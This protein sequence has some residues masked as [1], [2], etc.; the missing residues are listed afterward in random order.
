MQLG[1]G[2]EFADHREYYPGD[3]FRYLDW[4]VFARHDELLLKRFQEEE[5]LHVYLLLDC[6]RSMAFGD[7]VEVRLCPA[8]RRGAGLHRAGRP[9]PRRGGRLA[10]DIVADFPLTR[11]KGRIL[12]LLKFL[13]RL[14]TQGT[15]TD[16]PRV[17]TNFV[18]RGQRRGLA[19]V[20]SDLFDP[21]GFQGGLDLLR[22][23]RYEPHVVQ[24]V[25]PPR[26]RSAASRGTSSS[27][28][29]RAGRSAR[30]RSP[31]GTSGSTAR[32]SRDFLESVQT[33]CNAYGIGGT[34][35]VDRD[36][37]RRAAAADDAGG[38]SA[39]MSLVHPA[40]LL[41]A[42]LAMPIVVFYI[43]KVRLR[44]VPVSTLLFWEQIF[45][46]KKPRSLWQR[47]RHWI[48]L[49][50]QLAFLALLVFALA[51][52]IFRWQQARARRLVLVVD[53]SASMNA[54]DVLPSRLEVGQ[55]RGPPADRRPPAGRRAGDHRG[56][57]AAAG[58]LRHDRPP[59]HPPRG[60]R[61]DRARRRADPVTEAVA[62]ARRLLS[63]SEKI[64]QGRR[65]HR[66]RLRRRRRPGP[67]GRCRADRDRAKK[68]GNVGITRLQA[69]RSL[70]DPIGYEILVE[71]A[72]ASDGA[73]LVPA[74]ARPG[75]RPDRRRPAHAQ[76]RR[77][78]RPGLRE[79]LG[80]RRPAPRA[81]RSRRRPA[82]RQHRLGHPAQA[83]AGRRSR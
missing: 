11:G 25:R 63:G 45:E 70:V 80:R 82:G 34:L 66:R 9:R 20:L 15:V 49:L 59:A 18:H 65:P 47:L 58:R 61:H 21:K 53:N 55:G 14:E 79:D 41:L 72:N 26:G 42:A 54:S 12:S 13:E 40:A 7:P 77:A 17:V 74:G 57:A 64:A 19:V 2:I 37:V 60:A 36:P 32:S 76:A 1:G 4:N 22:H 68:T 62:L 23:H 28:T 30:S 71:V 6:S 78:E 29:S 33:Y 5:D 67:P 31:S 35:A 48:S 75:G 50:L 46:E 44:R 39:G 24:L 8:G 43:L 3:D 83:V 16:L 56:R 69:R 38:G 52:P 81:D 51:D 10:G 73:R 27:W